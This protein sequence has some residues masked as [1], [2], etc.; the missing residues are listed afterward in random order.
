MDIIKGYFLFIRA[1]WINQ[2][3]INYSDKNTVNL[4]LLTEN[5]A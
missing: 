3:A 2:H 5:V 4:S 1:Y